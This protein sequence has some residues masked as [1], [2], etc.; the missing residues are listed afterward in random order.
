MLLWICLLFLIVYWFQREGF[1]LPVV[2]SKEIKT[3]LTTYLQS[4][5]VSSTT[6]DT[7]I[8][9]YQKLG[10][11]EAD[12]NTFITTGKWPY[13]NDII[14]LAEKS[15]IHDYQTEFPQQ[16]FIQNF[17]RNDGT[18]QLSKLRPFN[19]MCKVDASGNSVGSG[20][21]TIESNNPATLVNNEDLPTT[22][23]G[24]QF[25]KQSCNP[26]NILNNVYDCPFAVPDNQG[27]TLLPSA[28]LRHVWNI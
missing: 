15:D 18:T 14:S 20:L 17:A 21:Y 24:F 10:V 23:K 25:M 5:N 4:K 6:I 9:L 19:L 22:V 27:Q 7:N 11:T 12:I 2:Y 1:S 26:C 3:K 8:A 28:W 16:Q 13:T